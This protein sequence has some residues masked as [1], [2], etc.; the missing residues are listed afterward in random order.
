MVL[1]SVHGTKQCMQARM[2]VITR[3]KGDYPYI[4]AMQ[5]YGISTYMSRY[6][7]GMGPN[8]VPMALKKCPDS[9]K[10]VFRVYSSNSPN[11][12]KSMPKW[13]T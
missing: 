7:A 4:H 9:Q 10:G 5:C 13:N 11:S 8:R 12:P 3:Y 1:L 6:G 2:Q